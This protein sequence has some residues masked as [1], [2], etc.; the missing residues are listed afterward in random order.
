MRAEVER[1]ILS[2]KLL[3]MPAQLADLATTL[4]AFMRATDERF[5]QV[6]K[7]FERLEATLAAFMRATDE[8]FAQVDKHF[9]RLEATLAAFMRATDERFERL[10][11]D[12][13]TVKGDLLEDRV[14][15]RPDDVLYEFIEA[16]TVLTRAQITALSR[17]RAYGLSQMSLDE[18]K[19]LRE[20]DV[21]I[22]AGH[23][24][25]TRSRISAVV[26]VSSRVGYSDI[27]RARRRSQI[28]ARHG[29]TS[30][31]IVVARHELPENL[32]H[33]AGESGVEVVV[34]GRQ[35]TDAA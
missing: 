18:A 10:E 14:K 21:V 31:A 25:S 35:A 30:L 5:A 17:E 34:V 33:L 28:L 27:E 7:H 4:A 23:A 22:V 29:H 20:A 16:G 24:P 19:D 9:E 26:E 32:V 12:L 6:D 8:R 2:E 15:T 3:S 1:T 11:A 13:G